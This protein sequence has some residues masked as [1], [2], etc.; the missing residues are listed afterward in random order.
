MVRIFLFPY[1]VVNLMENS[2]T[3][4]YNYLMFKQKP[5]PFSLLV[6]GI[7]IALHSCGSYYSLYWTYHEYDILVHIFAGL[8]IALVML[9]LASIFGYMN[10]LRGYKIRSFFIALISA[11]FFGIVWELLENF[12]QITFTNASSYGWNTAFDILG[13]AIGG[14]LAFLYFVQKRKRA[15]VT[16]GVLHPFYNQTGIIKS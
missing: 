4:C 12:S 15:D 9:W 5:F 11:I 10:S 1:P 14:I 8:W 6:L 16:S 3:E 2:A 13:D 7:L